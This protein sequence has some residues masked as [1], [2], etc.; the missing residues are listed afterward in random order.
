[1][2]GEHARPDDRTSIAFFDAMASS[3]SISLARTMAT[4]R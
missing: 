2:S 3:S 4:V 1:M